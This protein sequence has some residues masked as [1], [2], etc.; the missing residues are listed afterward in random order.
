MGVEDP[1][2]S[3]RIEEH[4]RERRHGKHRDRESQGRSDEEI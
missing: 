1:E 4:G 2:L 3:E